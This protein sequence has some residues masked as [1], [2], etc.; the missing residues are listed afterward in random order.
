MNL[1]KCIIV[2]VFFLFP[3]K[4]TYS[5][6]NISYNNTSEYDR[7]IN[8]IQE[9]LSCDEK[10]AV[11]FYLFI[12]YFAEG[13]QTEITYIAE[14]AE[15]MTIKEKKI[16]YTISKY[17]ESPYSNV[18]VSSLS[19]PSIFDFSIH[20]YLHRLARLRSRYHYT[21]VKIMFEPDYLGMS[22]VEKI[23]ENKYEISVAMWQMF[24]GYIGDTIVYSD[25]TRKKFRFL[26]DYSNQMPSV[27]ISEILVAET[28]TLDYYL[29]NRNR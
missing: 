4:Y 12:N 24:K 27:K 13:I 15:S 2:I 21:E 5:E 22:S 29:N 7:V 3:C 9:K 17:F 11:R 20:T 23:S 28:I 19:R 8:H 10:K 16:N 6:V 25:A 26:F 14:S 1:N 18:Q